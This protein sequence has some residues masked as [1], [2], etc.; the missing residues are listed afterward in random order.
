MS[1]ETCRIS[2]RVESE[3]YIAKCHELLDSIN[4]PFDMVATDTTPAR[5]LYN[6]LTTYVAQRLNSDCSNRLL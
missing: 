2:A 5:K 1:D 4:V 3:H 6:R